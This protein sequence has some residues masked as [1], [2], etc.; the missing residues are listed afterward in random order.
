M[1]IQNNR[2]AAIPAKGMFTNVK[3]YVDVKGYMNINI[4]LMAV[5][6]IMFLWGCYYLYTIYM[7]NGTLTPGT[8]PD[9]P[10][11]WET[12]KIVT[13]GD[14]RIATCKNTTNG[15][16]YTFSDSMFFGDDGYE[17]K[18]KFAAQVQ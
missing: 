3:N 12:V 16:V 13:A 15:R 10:P 14:K 1:A 18:K 7:Q 4:F 2:F 17:N 9:C 11:Y 5:G 6:M 8:V